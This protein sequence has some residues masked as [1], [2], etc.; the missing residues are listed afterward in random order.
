[1]HTADEQPTERPLS[2]LASKKCAP[3]ASDTPALKGHALTPLLKQLR[4]WEIINEH[5][6][7]KQ[8]RFPNFA[9]ALAFVNL[10][11]EIAQAEGHHPDIHLAW[12]RVDIRIWT[13]RIDGL[14]ESDFILAAKI[15]Q[16]PHG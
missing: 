12:G 9:T 3:C 5:H 16:L 7:S 8:F 14:T 2:E 6:L 10:V 1:M 13:D 11:G 4:G 15:D